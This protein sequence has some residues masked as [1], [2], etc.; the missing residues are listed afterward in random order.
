MAFLNSCSSLPDNVASNF[1]LAYNSIQAA[2]FGFE[3]Y[4]ITR[5]LVDQIPYASMRVK[6]GKGPAGLLI[7][8]SKNKK[9]KKW[10]SADGVSFIEKNGQ[11]V[12]TIGLTNNVT[13][14]RFLNDISFSKKIELKNMLNSEYFLSLDNPEVFELKVDLKIEN[15]GIE[16]IS[17]LDKELSLIHITEEKENKYIRWKLKDHY[18]VDPNDGFVWKSI[19]NIAPNLPPIF[20]EVTKKPAL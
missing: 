17:I 7:L 11:I 5:E 6:I 2:V 19:Q 18:W 14:I 13:N 1:K 8:E 10:T 15:E 9:Y 4:P 12:K 3:D 20:I 16:T